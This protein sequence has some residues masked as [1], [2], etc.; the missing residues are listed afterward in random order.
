MPFDLKTCIPMRCLLA[1]NGQV[2][3]LYK[4]GACDALGRILGRN[5]LRNV[6][7]DLNL[8]DKIAVPQKFIVL[9]NPESIKIKI[10]MPY[11]PGK[12]KKI[13][14]SESDRSVGI[15]IED[16]ELYV[17]YIERPENYVEP[18]AGFLLM[19][20]DFDVRKVGNASG[21]VDYGKGNE[22][23]IRSGKDGKIYFIDTESMKNFFPKK[24]KFNISKLKSPMY[25][26][27]LHSISFTLDSEDLGI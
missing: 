1:H 21:Y 26:P 12:N 3:R 22:N 24:N 13:F 7:E 15:D 8:T 17:E 2:L 19:S 20:N 4:K 10:S 14:C 11:A 5:H 23:F 18:K 25:D 9:K 27:R 16:A 6:I